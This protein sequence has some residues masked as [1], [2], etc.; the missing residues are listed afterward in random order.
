MFIRFAEKIQTDS[1]YENLEEPVFKYLEHQ[2]NSPKHANLDFKVNQDTG[3][4]TRV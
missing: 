3:R 4:C 1:F 2:R